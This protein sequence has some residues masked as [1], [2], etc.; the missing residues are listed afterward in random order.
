[1]GDE[2][3]GIKQEGDIGLFVG[4]YRGGDGDDVGVGIFEAV[5]IMAKG[6]ESSGFEIMDLLIGIARVLEGLDTLGVDIKADGGVFFAKFK[7]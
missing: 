4:I 2:L 3:G 5:C 7:G 1:M 6:E